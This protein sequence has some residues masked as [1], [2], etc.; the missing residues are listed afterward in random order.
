MKYLNLKTILLLAYIMLFIWSAINPID[1]NVWWVEALTSLIPVVL[2]IILYFRKIKFSNFG[3]ILAFIFPAMH[4]IGS[5]YTFALVP[6]DWFNNLIE[7]ERNMYDRLA[8]FSVGFYSFLIIEGLINFKLVAKKWL[9]YTYS[10]FFIIALS[11]IY[12]IFEWRYA[13]SADPSAGIAILG[14]QGDIWDAQKDMLMDTLGAIL[15]WILY[16]FFSKKDFSKK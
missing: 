16:L 6:F 7:S 11:A 9:A 5:H 1:F 15:G 2:L 12:E 4:I 3:Y 13:V 10:I 14:S 8:H